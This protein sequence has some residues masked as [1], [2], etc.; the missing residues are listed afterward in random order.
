MPFIIHERRH[1]VSFHEIQNILPVILLL[2][3]QYFLACID[4]AVRTKGMIPN[5]LFYQPASCV[6]PRQITV[7]RQIDNITR[8]RFNLS[9]HLVKLCSRTA[10]AVIHTQICRNPGKN[11][12]RLPDHRI[13]VIPAD[14]QSMIL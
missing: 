5:T 4:H 1:T 14:H 6:F 9:D 8:K 3:P 13:G 11:L 10:G 7:L 2:K 12:L